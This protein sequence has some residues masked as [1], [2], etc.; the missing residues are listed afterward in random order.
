[1]LSSHHAEVA[2]HQSESRLFAS[3]QPRGVFRA[4]GMAES[5]KSKPAD[6][7]IGVPIVRQRTPDVR[8]LRR[9]LREA[10]AAG[11][12]NGDLWHAGKAFL[13]GADG[14]DR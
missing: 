13:D 2:D 11:V 4:V 10:N 8:G 12:E 3:E 6:S 1:M 7:Q 9:Q 5:V 14:V